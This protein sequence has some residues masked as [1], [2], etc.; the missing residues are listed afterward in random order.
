M[1]S[2]KKSNTNRKLVFCVTASYKGGAGK[3]SMAL[4]IAERH[5]ESKNVLFLDTDFTG[6]AI[7][8]A[9]DIEKSKQL[10]GDEMENLK[11]GNGTLDRFL[12]EVPLETLW[13]AV[14]CIHPVDTG[15]GSYYI[16]PSV[17]DSDRRKMLEPLLFYG[18]DIPYI[19]LRLDDFILDFLKSDMIDSGKDTL[20][21]IDNG[22][23]MYGLTDLL[24]EHPLEKSIAHAFNRGGYGEVEVMFLLACTPDLQDQV[25]VK[26]E[27]KDHWNV[28]YL[29]NNNKII[30]NLKSSER[31]S[32]EK[33]KHFHC[34]LMICLNKVYPDETGE[35][36]AFVDKFYFE[37]ALT[38]RKDEVPV[39][40][41][42]FD[43]D[44]MAKQFIEKELNKSKSSIVKKR[45]DVFK[46]FLEKFKTMT[47]S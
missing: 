32:K 41:I 17:T 5:A 26:R 24:V 21:I 35:I 23:G 44:L 18:G 20:V 19:L 29:K 15:K 37:A 14:D 2:G 28:D 7:Y 40:L 47:F 9:I 11:V 31:I 13:K 34:R 6:T 4:A 39:I 25:V 43:P 46:E 12:A 8:D 3:S 33:I 36:I 42:F 27:L 22:P 38:S 45:F 1:K 30:S 16:A 10:H